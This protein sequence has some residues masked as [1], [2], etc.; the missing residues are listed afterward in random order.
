MRNFIQYWFKYETILNSRSMYSLSSD[1][2]D[3]LPLTP[4]HFLIGKPLMLAPDPDLSEMKFNK[5]SRLQLLQN[6]NQDFWTAWSREYFSSIQRR[7]KWRSLPVHDINIGN[8]VLIK[9]DN[10]PPCKWLTGRI[11]DLHPGSDKVVRVV[12]VKTAYGVLKRS[13]TKLCLL[14]LPKTNNDK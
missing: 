7:N 4:S 2:N 14:P 12:T 1:P 3:F 6:M 8:L 13:I 5:L 9:E 11:I 10:L